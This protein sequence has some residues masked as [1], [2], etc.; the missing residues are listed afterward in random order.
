MKS[1][2]LPILGAG[3]WILGVILFILGLNIHTTAGQWMT[4]VGEISFFVGLGLE[5]VIWMKKRKDKEEKT[6]EKG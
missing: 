5:G 1:N 6:E 3:L 2:I 4:V